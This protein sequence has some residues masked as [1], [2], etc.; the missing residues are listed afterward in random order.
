MAYLPFISDDDFIKHVLYVLDKGIKAREEAEKKFYKNVIDPFSALFE[1]AVKEISLDEWKYFEQ[2]RQNQKTLQNAVG[3]FHEYILGSVDGWRKFDKGNQIDLANEDN[4]IIAEVKNKHNTVTGGKLVDHYVEFDDLVNNKSS[5]YHGATAY[6]VQVIPKTSKPY[7]ICFTPSD[8]A[9]G[10]KKPENERIRKIDGRS[11][12]GM[13]TGIDDA[14]DQLY[15]KI[16]EVI[17]DHGNIDKE[18]TSNDIKE[19]VS[20][21]EKAYSQ[22]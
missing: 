12:Y 20:F 18:F 19:L 9:K 16:P 6:F 1:A 17:H 8:K 15:Q 13:V 10:Y 5:I 7:N 2:N 11:F 3:E 14:L 22:R 21:F 4:S